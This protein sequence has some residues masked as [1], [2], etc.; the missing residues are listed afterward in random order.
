MVVL[1]SAASMVDQISS[2]SSTAVAI[3]SR[4][5]IISTP[6]FVAVAMNA[7]KC[8]G[9]VVLIVGDQHAPVACCQG[10][11]LRIAQTRKAS[12]RCGL[13]IQGGRTADDRMQNDLVQIRVSLKA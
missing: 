7:A 2:K 9:M 1:H 8:L 12:S 13:E 3:G 10:Q 5:G 4:C 11:H 6:G